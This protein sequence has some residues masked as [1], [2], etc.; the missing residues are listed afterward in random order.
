MAEFAIQTLGWNPTRIVLAR[1]DDPVDAASA[2]PNA[3]ENRAPLLFIRSPDQ[4]GTAAADFL[5]AHAGTIQRI[6]VLGGPG[7][8]SDAL[9]AQARAAVG[10][11]PSHRSQAYVVRLLARLGG[12]LGVVQ[13]RIQATL[14]QQLVVLATLH[15]PAIRHDQNLVSSAHR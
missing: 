4:L 8:V 10:G 12:E 15:D 3:G 1:G 7:A 2:A 6:D 11:W 14:R 13:I 5:R 9:I